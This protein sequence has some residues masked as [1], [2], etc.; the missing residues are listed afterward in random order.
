MKLST[1]QM[2]LAALMAALLSVSAQLAVPI[3]DTPFTMQML[4]VF[5]LPFL[6][7]PMPAFAAMG[8]YL[9]LGLLGLPVFA[10]GGGGIAYVLKPSFGFLLGMT[11]IAPLCSFVSLR[12]KPK[13]PAGRLVLTGGCMAAYLA[14]VYV[15]GATYMYFILPLSGGAAISY[16]AAWAMAV[17]PFIWVDILKLAAALTLVAVLRPALEK[18]HLL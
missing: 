4:V 12:I 10:A 18:A 3:G 16:G 6:L 2:M 15:F 9:L 13:K 11:L 1:K 8:I 7:R 5:V 14:L 17:V